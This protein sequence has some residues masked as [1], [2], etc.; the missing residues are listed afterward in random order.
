MSFSPHFSSYPPAFIEL[1]ERG[2]KADSNFI[3]PCSDAK[4]A[5]RV[6]MIFHGIKYAIRKAKEHPLKDS[7]GAKQIIITKNHEVIFRSPCDSPLQHKGEALLAAAL[8]AN[9]ED[10][11]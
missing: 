7:L 11:E 2:I 1:Y 5:S 4:E 9:V 8:A 6:R 3:I 10:K